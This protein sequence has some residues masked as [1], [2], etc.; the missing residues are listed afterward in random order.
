MWGVREGWVWFHFWSDNGCGRMVWLPVDFLNQEHAKCPL[1]WIKT[2]RSWE[3][4]SNYI[5]CHSLVYRL[6][7]VGGSIIATCRRCHC[8][9]QLN[10]LMALHGCLLPAP[11]PVAAC[12][13]H[14]HRTRGQQLL[15]DHSVHSNSLL[16]SIHQTCTSR[17]SRVKS[18][19][20]HQRLAASIKWKK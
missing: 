15:V 19:T 17:S 2:V 20:S 5:R 16:I 8:Q 18:S 14:V 4:Y 11:A 1:S 10:L 9:P 7:L 13:L 3:H 6:S 12:Q